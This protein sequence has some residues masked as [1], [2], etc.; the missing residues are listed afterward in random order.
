VTSDE[1]FSRTAFRAKVKTPFEFIASA[2]RAFGIDA[3]TTAATV[4]VLGR[5]GQ[6]VYGRAEPDGWPDDAASWMNGG[7]L[8][9]RVLIAG[10]IADAKAPFTDVEHW[11][12]WSRLRELPAE[13]QA[14]SVVAVFLGGFASEATKTAIASAPGDGEQRLATMVAI[15]LGAPEFQRR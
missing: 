8:L 10:D 7:A 1:F 2:R 12:G 5:L 3:D 11:R 15:A 13:T 6:P 9:N 14:D 4:Q